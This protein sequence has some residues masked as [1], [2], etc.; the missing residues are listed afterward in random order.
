MVWGYWQ[1]IDGE[2]FDARTEF[3]ALVGKELSWG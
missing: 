2:D 3:Q 1:T